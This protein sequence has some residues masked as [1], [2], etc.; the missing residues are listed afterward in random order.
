MDKNRGLF[1]KMENIADTS[2]SSALNAYYFMRVLILDVFLQI[3]ANDGMFA[4]ISIT[5]VYLYM[6]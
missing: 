4:A 3:L 5:I 1:K 6:R 2:H